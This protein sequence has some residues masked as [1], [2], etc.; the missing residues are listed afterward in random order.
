MFNNGKESEKMRM[1]GAHFFIFT[2]VKKKFDKNKLC[3]DRV[4]V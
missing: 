4:N 2:V 1:P 3:Y